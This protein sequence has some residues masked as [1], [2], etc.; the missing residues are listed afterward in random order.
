MSAPTRYDIVPYP[1]KAY[2]Y[3]HPDRLF[4]VGRLFG[5]KPVP[6]ARARVLELGCGAG[7]HLVPMARQLPEGEFVGLDLAQT[8]IRDARA[9]AA[10]EGLTNVR[11]DVADILD[12]PD[13][14][15]TFDYIVAHGVFSWI[16]EP[17]R[18]ALMGAIPK[19]LNPQGVAYVSY[20]T[21]PGWHLHNAVRDVMRVHAEAFTDPTEQVEQ[22]KAFV[23]FVHGF[24]QPDNAWAA[25]LGRAVKMIDNFTDGYFFHDFLAPVND[26]M[27]FRDFVARAERVGLQY[28]GDAV[29]GEML[30]TRLPDEVRG[31]LQRVAKD[32]V[33]MEQ[34]MDLVR[35]TAF[36]RSLLTATSTRAA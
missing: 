14:L 13:D 17:A 34:Y 30:P 8:A 35:G 11:F 2:A 31:T 16:P 26:P 33:S 6:P 5:M 15:G 7:G 28:L 10:A 25:A 4:V 22:A 18:V 27:L 19:L 36:R 12:L 9:L 24:V 21:Y 1:S 23:K 3:A 32:I 20:N 29:F